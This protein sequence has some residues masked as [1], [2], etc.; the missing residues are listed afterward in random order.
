MFEFADQ[1]LLR[2]VRSVVRFRHISQGCAHI[3]QESNIPFGRISQNTRYGV[4][5][6]CIVLINWR[7]KVGSLYYGRLGAGFQ[8]HHY[9]RSD[10]ALEDHEE[11]HTD[12]QVGHFTHQVPKYADSKSAPFQLLISLSCI[13]LGAVLSACML[14]FKLQLLLLMADT[15]NSVVALLC[16]VTVSQRS[17]W[18]NLWPTH[19]ILV[20]HNASNFHFLRRLLCFLQMYVLLQAHASLWHSD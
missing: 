17:S 1:G 13:L 4:S 6:D 14:S 18:W 8:F 19:H 10:N 11:W 20:Y 16:L 12:Y 7:S 3:P 2:L 5:L 9:R 15:V